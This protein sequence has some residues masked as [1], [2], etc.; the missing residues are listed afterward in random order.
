MTLVVGQLDLLRSTLRPFDVDLK[1]TFVYRCELCF[2]TFTGKGHLLTI[3]EEK[4]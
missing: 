4:S 1:V 2:A 3:I